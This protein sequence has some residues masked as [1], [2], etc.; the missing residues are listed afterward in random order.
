MKTHPAFDEL[1]A[2]AQGRV[3]GVCDA[4]EAAWQGAVTQAGAAEVANRR[5]GSS[6]WPAMDNFLN[7]LGA[8]ERAAA[9]RELVPIDVSY[10]RQCGAPVAIGIYSRFVELDADWLTEIVLNPDGRTKRVETSSASHPAA[11]SNPKLPPPTLEVFIERL[12]ASRLLDRE[13]VQREVASLK[14]S[15][16]ETPPVGWT[17]RP[18][19]SG[20]TDEASILRADD[21]STVQPTAVALGERMV[22]RG[23]LT[24]FQFS[25]LLRLQKSGLVLGEYII[26]SPI[27]RG[28]MGAV[29][30]ARHRRMDRIVAIKVLS[31][32]AARDP[33]AASRFSREI[34]AIARLTHPNIVAAHDAGEDSGV[35]YL[36]MEYINGTDLTTCVRTHGPL[37]TAHAV[38]CIIQAAEGL[39]YAHAQG[40]I[41]RDIKPSNLILCH[42]PSSGG[43]TV[44]SADSRSADS[45]QPTDPVPTT[46]PG[47]GSPH[48]L[49]PAALQIKVLD[50][51]LARFQADATAPREGSALTRSGMM[52][53]T[54]EYMAPE[55]AVNAST[56][57]QRADIYSLGCTLFFL[58]TGRPVLTGQTFLETVMA[59][60]LQALPSLTAVRSDVPAELDQIFRR[61][62]ARNPEQRPASMREVHDALRA[63]PA[64]RLSRVPSVA[65]LKPPAQADASQHAGLTEWFAPLQ[66]T[67]PM[68][69]ATVLI[70]NL[71]EPS[72]PRKPTS[73]RSTTAKSKALM[74]LAAIVG[75]LLCTTGVWWWM[76]PG[77][78]RSNAGKSGGATQ[79]TPSNK[80]APPQ[81]LMFPADLA[82]VQ[83]CQQ[84]WAAH[85]KTQPIVTNGVGIKLCLIPPGEFQ[86]GTPEAEFEMLPQWN[87]PQYEITRV[88]NELPA[89]HVRL[90]KPFW[91]S[92]TE[93][94]VAQFRRFVDEEHFVTETEQTAGYGI[95]DN[96][97]VL[98]RG[99]SWKNVGEATMTDDHSASNLTWN[100][101]VA[102][103]DWMSRRESRESRRAVRYRLPTEA[104]WEYACRAGTETPWYGGSDIATVRNYGFFAGNA[105]GRLQP[106]G[107]KLEN[108]FHLFDMA[109][110]QA[111]WCHDWFAAYGNT[112][113]ID[114][115]GPLSGQERVQRGGNFVDQPLHLRSASRQSRPQSSP[116]HGSLRLVRED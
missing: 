34:R 78:G 17:P 73:F 108:P 103:C 50:L 46:P 10:R 41:H 7:E 43:T 15:A 35:A 31:P 49:A 59:H 16:S 89:H 4:F 82:A 74:S 92:Q 47:D 2:E 48:A 32:S 20:R 101:A 68:R 27:G 76:Q 70:P 111:E 98:Q 85:L 106:V 9:L 88:R 25:S 83:R 94:T 54:P 63:I 66:E 102:F 60:Q 38:E 104:E 100:D 65:V 45:R 3:D 28:G 107:M 53:G 13:T 105:T 86:M 11:V 8:D 36:V 110:N 64:E 42:G 81:P 1:S 115:T 109:G 23:M 14:Q 113:A 95:V 22:S 112:E 57:D 114:P 69:A 77:D 96:R 80:P 29:Y 91:I 51:G 40:V 18:S 21:R 72:A 26:L 33:Q 61:M 67:D 97:W 116:Q 24:P 5:P 37:S 87:V 52:F 71:D 90:T 44:A 84:K 79:P 56:V 75:V 99:F 55:Q 12:V 19:E 39:E 30:R 6:H 58:L 62:T 93:V